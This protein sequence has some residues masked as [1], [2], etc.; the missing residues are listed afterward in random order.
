MQTEQHNIFVL[1]C[2]SQIVRYSTATWPK[3]LVRIQVR[4]EQMVHKRTLRTLY[5]NLTRPAVTLVECMNMLY[6]QLP[7]LL[8]EAHALNLAGLDSV[9]ELAV[10]PLI[11]LR[12]LV[13]VAALY[14][15]GTLV[16]ARELH[17]LLGLVL[18]LALCVALR[19]CVVVCCVGNA[20]RA[21]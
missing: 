18:D 13:V 16:A 11:A 19:W 2:R 3:F 5:S 20:G 6:L 4:Q 8:A 17:R 15:R 14:C 21:H 7:A 10:A 1:L 12:Q 9:D